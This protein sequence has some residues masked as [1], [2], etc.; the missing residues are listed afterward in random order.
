MTVR[1]RALFRPVD[2]ASLVAFRVA[3]GLLMLVAVGRYFAH[4]WIADLF[5]ALMGRGEAAPRRDESKE[6]A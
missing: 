1:V 4:G 5:V 6:A 3:F 2:I